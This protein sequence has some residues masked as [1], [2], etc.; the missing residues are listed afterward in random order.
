MQRTIVGALS[1]QK[2]HSIALPLPPHILRP[3]ARRLPF[4]PQNTRLFT[5]TRALS[6]P[7]HGNA[8]A[9][10]MSRTGETP[11]WGAVRVRQ[12]FLDYFKER[13][14]TF[15]M[16]DLYLHCYESTSKNVN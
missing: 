10:N 12:T 11:E 15:G 6:I 1:H 16:V 8:Q 13:G 14:H 5:R 4:N 3:S 9:A 2:G 7:L